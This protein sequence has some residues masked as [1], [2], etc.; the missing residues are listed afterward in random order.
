MTAPYTNQLINRVRQD[1]AYSQNRNRAI[2]AL[3]NSMTAR[4][5]VPTNSGLGVSAIGGGTVTGGFTDSHGTR[6]ATIATPWGQ[7][8]TVNANA[9][10]KFQALFKGLNALGYHP[11]SAGGYNYRN[12]AGT[13]TLSKHALGFAVDL[14]PQQNR[15]GRLGGG[16]TRY[17][18]FDPNSVLKL[19][20]SLGLSWGATFSNPD[21]MHFSIGEG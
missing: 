13:N 18:Y 12:I 8:V 1:I 17:G 4:I 2:Q 10:G 3:G 16:G 5:Q 7:H 20:R 21:P 6:L 11:K 9:A 15:G 14:D 19:A